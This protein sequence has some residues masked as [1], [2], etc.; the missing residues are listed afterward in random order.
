MEKTQDKIGKIITQGERDAVHVAVLP[1]TA[2]TYLEPG[3]HIGYADG[4]SSHENHIGI[5]D[6][7]L[8]ETVK[9]GEMFF[10]FL[11][12][13]TITSLHHLWTHPSINEDKL[14]SEKWLRTFA[15]I[16]DCPDYDTLLSA[17]TGGHVENV[18]G[19]GASYNNDGEYLYFNGRDAHG[20]IPPEFWHHVE[21]ITDKKI[22]PSKK[23]TYFCCSC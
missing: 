4:K 1:M 10:M 16:A 20:E 5:V 18:D 12:P 9:Q 11:Y 14:A 22:D 2:E 6:P 23:A 17:A 7:F 15:S 8:K 21:V 13:N 3:Q 19:Y